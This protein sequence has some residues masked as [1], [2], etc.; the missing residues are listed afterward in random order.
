MTGF[1]ALPDI[2]PSP[3]QP[4]S[5]IGGLQCLYTLETSG[6][7]TPC[8]MLRLPALCEFGLFREK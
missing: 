7:L 1:P 3:L 6:K 2:P 4:A 8:V 5:Y